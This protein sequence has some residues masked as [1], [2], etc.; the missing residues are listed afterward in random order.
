MKRTFE[1][2]LKRWKKDPVFR[3]ELEKE[4]KDSKYHEKDCATR[5]YQHYK[6]SCKGEK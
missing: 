2:D 3:K 6:C 1:D 4:M 5:V